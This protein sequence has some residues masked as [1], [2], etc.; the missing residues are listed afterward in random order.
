MTST[1]SS[2]G[3]RR[4][5]GFAQAQHRLERGALCGVELA[6]V[7]SHPAVLHEGLLAVG[8]D[9]ADRRLQVDV[10]RRGADPDVDGAGA[11][12]RRVRGQRSGEVGDGAARRA[13][14]PLVFGSRGPEAAV[15]GGGVAA[16]VGLRQRVG[17]PGESVG[18]R[19]RP[20]A[21]RSGRR[22]ARGTR[23]W[24]RCPAPGT[25]RRTL[26]SRGRAGPARAPPA[27][28]SKRTRTGF[29]SSKAA[30]APS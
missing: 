25:R 18:A 20:A 4:D 19:A 24:P 12:H 1:N 5:V 11:D 10:G 7:A 27:P 8:P 16:E 14:F 3:Q 17:V 29:R 15:A 2:A 13:L 28:L 21:R 26:R 30:S 22:P 6:L 23:P 9:L